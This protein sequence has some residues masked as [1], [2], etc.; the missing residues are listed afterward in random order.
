MGV[1]FVKPVVQMYNR[2]PKYIVQT[3][4]RWLKVVNLL[5]AIEK[6]GALGVL[7]ESVAGG[8][9]NRKTQITIHL[10]LNV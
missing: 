8:E 10:F 5:E 9:V 7:I 1:Y 6:K 4:I 2:L 3:S